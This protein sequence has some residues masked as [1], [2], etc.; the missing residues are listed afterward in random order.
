[1]EL[2]VLINFNSSSDFDN[3]Q[4]IVKTS[5]K[6]L[7]V[8]N[9][10]NANVTPIFERQ[11]KNLWVIVWLNE[12]VTM[13]DTINFLDR[14]LWKLHWS[15]IM[16]IAELTADN[17]NFM[18][19][20]FKLCWSKGFTNV[21]LWQKGQLYN[22]QPFPK[23][24]VINVTSVKS[25]L[26][27]KQEIDFK[28]YIFRVPFTRRPPQS[29]S[30]RNQHGDL[31]FA[32]YWFKIVDIFNKQYN[33]TTKIFPVTLEETKIRRDILK[34]TA[35]KLF[36]IIPSSMYFSDYYSNSDV[37]YLSKV[38]VLC[39]VS[40]E[41]PESLYLLITFDRNVWLMCALTFIILTLLIALI[42]RFVTNRWHISTSC[43]DALTTLTNISSNYLKRRHSFL[44][45]ILH[46]MPLLSGFLLTNFHN[47]NLSS[48]LTAK[49]YEDPLESLE[50]I[51]K[52]NVK[53]LE[54]SYDIDHT[55][56]LESVPQYIKER[57]TT[58]D[59]IH[60]FVRLRSNL[61]IT[62]YFYTGPEDLADFFLFQ[63][64]YLPRPFA[65]ALSE[66][67]YHKPFFFTVPHR[68]PFLPLFNRYLL[69][70]HENGLYD[71]LQHDAK[72]DGVV[73]GE[74][75]F[76]LPSDLNKSLSLDYLSSAFILLIL[77]LVGS[78]LVFLLE[79]YS[80]RKLRK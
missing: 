53:I 40:P 17:N 51:S 20:L 80:V 66:A 55:L 73:S 18:Q 59:S 33:G 61:E 21:L 34:L 9:N 57:L 70:V 49:I 43:L 36:D 27:A 56:T 32:G 71:K 68:S 58:I 67:I 25:Y 35:T 69:Y 30:Y 8:Y 24:Q 3:Y 7:I 75:K 45:F 79:I 74:L 60:E 23:V 37:F 64:K 5:D 63:Q 1:M 12:N 78:I 42:Y 16:F 22:Y 41:I 72:W 31:V 15:E 65:T 50:D 10:I 29:F 62:K 19:L 46:F 28:G 44:M 48:M 13:N 47:C 77:G 39:S 26:D 38:V 6:P 76:F 54:A 2:N 4:E 14:I 52:T 11:T